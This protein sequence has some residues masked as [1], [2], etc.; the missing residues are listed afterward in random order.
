MSYNIIRFRQGEETKWGVEDH[1]SVYPL[2]ES[3][4]TLSDFIVHGTLEAKELADKKNKKPVSLDTV[5]ILSPVTS[6][7]QIICQGL[8]YIS[9]VNETDVNREAPKYNL[10][11]SK[12]PSSLTKPQSDII[13][14]EGVK[15]LDYEI[16]LGLIIGKNIT[17]PYQVTD[18]NISDLIAGIIMVNDISARDIQIPQGQWFKGKSFR[19]FCPAGPFLC[20]LDKDDLKKL[21]CLE[22]KLWVNGEL[23]QSATT[24]D[25]IFKPV[26]TLTEISKIMDL[27]TGDLLI[28]GTPGGVALQA[29][30]RLKQKIATLLFPETHRMEIFVKNQMSMPYYLKNND[31]I[32]STIMSGDGTINLGKQKLRIEGSHVTGP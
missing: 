31:I 19:T 22:L 2:N 30:G 16:E 28:T 14:P 25:M 1:N 5:E 4:L 6:P 8:N 18:E 24:A 15:L 26:E 20:L 29:P 27:Y 32:E 12:A 13:R 10:L 21:F 7:C 11:F 9:H 3:Y 23:R 17:R